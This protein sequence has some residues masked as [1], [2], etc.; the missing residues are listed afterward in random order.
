MKSLLDSFASKLKKEG[1]K[2]IVEKELQTKYKGYVIDIEEQH[3]KMSSELEKNYQYNKIKNL[4]KT[5]TI[6]YHM[7]L[8]LKDKG[9]L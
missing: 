1:Y 9:Q 6:N 8:Y 5:V 2:F 3:P 4:V 7:F